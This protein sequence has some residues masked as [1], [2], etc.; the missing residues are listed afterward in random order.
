MSCGPQK[1]DSK[2]VLELF[3]VPWRQKIF[4]SNSKSRHLPL[5]RASLEWS[6]GGLKKKFCGQPTEIFRKNVE[7]SDMGFRVLPVK[8]KTW[9][10]FH[11]TRRTSNLWSTLVSARLTALVGCKWPGGQ[12]WTTSTGTAYTLLLGI[13][14]RKIECWFIF[15]MNH[16]SMTSSWV[17]INKKLPKMRFHRGDSRET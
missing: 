15:C 7:I 3:K 17:I 9:K 1:S 4:C 5:D 16:D 2:R 12:K 8:G 6:T 11:S 13:N 14:R 10:Y